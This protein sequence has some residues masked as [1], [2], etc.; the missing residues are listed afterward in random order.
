MTK[1]LENT[2]VSLPVI[3]WDE[4]LHVLC[5]QSYIMEKVLFNQKTNITNYITAKFTE[6]TSGNIIESA[7]Q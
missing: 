3:L 6:Q 1:L 4:E 7:H 2:T 5:H